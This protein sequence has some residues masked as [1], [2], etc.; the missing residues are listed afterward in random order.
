MTIRWSFLGM[1][2]PAVVFAQAAPLPPGNPVRVWAHC[3]TPA[4]GDR[5]CQQVEGTL[6]RT[7]PDSLVMFR[8]ERRIA[9]PLAAIDSVQSRV[10]EGSQAGRGALFGILIGTAV[11]TAF[12]AAISN[13]CE[14]TGEGS[15]VTPLDC[16]GFGLIYGGLP[17]LVIGTITGA[18]IPRHRWRLVEVGKTSVALHVGPSLSGAGARVGI[19]IRF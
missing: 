7:T 6:D 13:G 17:G 8:Q 3:T 15:N 12:G 11:V 14:S 19:G 4:A 16:I 1:M 10:T 2:A 18:L 5:G 9:L